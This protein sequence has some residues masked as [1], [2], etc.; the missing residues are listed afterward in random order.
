MQDSES[1]YDDVEPVMPLNSTA[2]SI[3]DTENIRSPPQTQINLESSTSNV[4]ISMNNDHVDFTVECN[5]EVIGTENNKSLTD[6]G[7]LNSSTLESVDNSSSN[8]NNDNCDGEDY[9]NDNS[10]NDSDVEDYSDADSND[11]NCDLNN[12]NLFQ[13]YVL[14]IPL[15]S[16]HKLSPKDHLLSILAMSIRHNLSYEATLDFCKLINATYNLRC[17]PTTKEALWSVLE[18]DERLITYHQYCSRCCEYLGEGRE[19]TKDCSCNLCGPNQKNQCLKYFLS[20]NLSLQIANLLA[21]PNIFESLKYRFTRM[22]K[23]QDAIEDIYDG[24]KYKKLCEP[25]KF[26]SN[27]NNFS[28]S[29]N[30][31]GCKLTN[32]SKLSAWPIYVQI[33]ELPPHLRKKHFLLAGIFVATME[34]I[35]NDYL[36]PFTD[37]I[38]ALY[39]KEI[40][41]KPTPISEVQSK[42]VALLQDR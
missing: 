29:F 14:D 5:D 9:Q 6:R 16:S 23:D 2:N 1:E 20:L 30:T 39:E 12:T 21:I 33:N 37:Q 41:W 3:Q 13:S 27:P 26:L 10:S 19:P 38:K 17:L 15:V 25:G 40:I 36:R 34:P 18:K 7:N 4:E 42:F 24:A 28:F 22:K 31:D 32:S 8:N 11:D 35:M